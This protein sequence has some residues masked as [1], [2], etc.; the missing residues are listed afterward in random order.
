MG[1]SVVRLQAFTSWDDHELA[2]RYQSQSAVSWMKDVPILDDVF[3][4]L[5]LVYEELI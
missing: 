4:L 5:K 2:Y 3:E 1:V